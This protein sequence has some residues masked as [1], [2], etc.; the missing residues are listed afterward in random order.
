[1][2][3]APNSTETSQDFE[4]T[5]TL[6]APPDTV[7]AALRT[8][9]AI[10]DWW[11][12]TEGLAAVGG[13]FRVT[14]ASHGQV[15]VLRVEPGQDGEVV[16][17]VV[18]TPRTPEWVGTR[19]VFDVRASGSGSVLHFR[20]HGLTPELECFDM[21]HEGWTHYLGSLV[22]YVD[23]GEGQPARHEPAA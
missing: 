12:P 3:T 15:I 16:W 1:M 20:H 22:S 4:S 11:G 14:F 2:S 10:T 5:K 8:P 9:E 21:C 17:N 18:E 7:L 6:S 13:T 19:I 23:T